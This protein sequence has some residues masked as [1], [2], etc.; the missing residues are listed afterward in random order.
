[1]EGRGNS[2]E[3]VVKG[4]MN[5]NSSLMIPTIADP[6]EERHAWK[7]TETVTRLKIA[8]IVHFEG[9][10]ALRVFID[11]NALAIW[12]KKLTTYSAMKSQDVLKL[13]EA[14]GFTRISINNGSPN[15][16]VLEGVH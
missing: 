13:C 6:A 4:L 8:T 9:R 16:F 11:E 7:T 15:T 5:G 3:N 14:N 10:K 2:Y 12:M 1:M